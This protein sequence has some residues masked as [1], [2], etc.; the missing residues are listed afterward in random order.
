MYETKP[1]YFSL[2]MIR[3]LVKKKA[4][5]MDHNRPHT[6]MADILSILNLLKIDVFIK[7]GETYY[8]E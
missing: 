7:I 6:T 5:E 3:N 4:R 8:L 1:P 2:Y